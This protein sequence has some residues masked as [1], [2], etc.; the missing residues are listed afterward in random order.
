MSDIED[1]SGPSKDHGEKK[2]QDA[3]GGANKKMVKPPAKPQVPRMLIWTGGMLAPL[4]KTLWPQKDLQDRRKKTP[5]PSL[6]AALESR[7]Q[8]DSVEKEST[9][10]AF[11]AR[12]YSIPSPD[13]NDV[14]RKFNRD[15]RLVAAGVFGVLL[16]TAWAFVIFVPERADEATFLRSIHL[17]TNGSS[18]AVT[19]AT[20]LADQRSTA[21]YS[22]ENPG[23]MEV[24]G[25]SIPSPGGSRRSKIVDRALH[26]DNRPIRSCRAMWVMRRSIAG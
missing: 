7:Q 25:T 6:R 24:P 1:Y 12:G 3:L 19:S 17:S 20:L 9:V 2:G 8:F 21:S 11:K 10:P 22:K 13:A 16:L 26:L 5:I 18:G 4:E 14:L 15:I 23:R